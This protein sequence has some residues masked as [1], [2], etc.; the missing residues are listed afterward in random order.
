MGLF[1]IEKHPEKKPLEGV[2]PNS[3]YHSLT[4]S[5]GPRE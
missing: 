1:R 5:G 3:S 4:Q 2:G